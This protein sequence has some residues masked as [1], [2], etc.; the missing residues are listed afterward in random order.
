MADHTLL[1]RDTETGATLRCITKSV[2]PSVDPDYQPEDQRCVLRTED[3]E[4][5][6]WFAAKDTGARQIIASPGV[7][8]DEYRHLRGH[9]QVIGLRLD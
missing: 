1:Y 5:L 7:P 4:A 8:P 9:P 6:L 3:G 2:H